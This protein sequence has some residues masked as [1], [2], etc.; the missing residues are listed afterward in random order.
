MIEIEIVTAPVGRWGCLPCKDER[1][2][3]EGSYNGR[4]AAS[5]CAPLAEIVTRLVAN[6]CSAVTSEIGL[7]LAS[8][9][10]NAIG[11][12]ERPGNLAPAVGRSTLMPTRTSWVSAPLLGS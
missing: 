7:P 11:M 3:E 10:W 4:E 6:S 8:V 5:D 9:S 2:G 12:I 1:I